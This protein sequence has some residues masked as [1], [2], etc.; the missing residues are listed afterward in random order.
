MPTYRVRPSKP[1]AVF[2]AI[3]G[4]VILGAGL[5]MV[6]FDGKGGW[7]IWLWL[8]LG[9]AIIVF[10]LWSAFGKKGHVQTITTDDDD[11]PPKR[12]G[13]DVTKDG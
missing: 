3:F 6:G 11:G 10:N 9:V 8:A 7:F 1:M 12:F 2:G 13:M 5:V 4:V